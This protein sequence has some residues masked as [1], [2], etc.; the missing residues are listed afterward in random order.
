MTLNEISKLL[1]CEVFCGEDQLN[2]DI[3]FG[4]ASDLMSDVLAFSRS[5]AILLTGLVNTQTIHTAFIAEI[6]AVVFVR[7]KK[8]DKDIVALAR[9]KHIPLLGTPY[10]LYEAS[11]I[12]YKTGL[13]STMECISVKN[14]NG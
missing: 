3:E 8:P 2:M 4:C 12:L 10:S 14:E 13:I 5:G 7:R 6:N 9:E 1:S 11:G